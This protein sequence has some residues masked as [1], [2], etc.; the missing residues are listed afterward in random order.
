MIGRFQIKE[1][2]PSLAKEDKAG[3]SIG[4]YLRR[5]LLWRQSQQEAGSEGQQITPYSFRHRFSAEGHARGLKPKQ[6]AASMGHDLETPM[7]V[8]QVY[9]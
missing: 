7:K 5:K 1:S 3:E 2:L 6:L 9:E 8:M 4:T